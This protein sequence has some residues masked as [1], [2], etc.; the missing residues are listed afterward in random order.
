MDSSPAICTRR[1]RFTRLRTTAPPT[2]LDTTKPIRGGRAAR[3]SVRLACTTRSRDPARAPPGRLVTAVNSAPVRSRCRAGSTGCPSGGELGAALPATGGED[4]PTGAGA[5]PVA[6]AVRLGAT[7][8]VR[9]ERALAHGGW[10]SSGRGCLDGCVRGV[11]SGPMCGPTGAERADRPRSSGDTVGRELSFGPLAS[12]PGKHGASRVATV[13]AGE[14]G[15]DVSDAVALVC[16]GHLIVSSQ[17]G[18]R[19]AS[20]PG[21]VKRPRS[22][23]RGSPLP[24]TSALPGGDT[25]VGTGRMAEISLLRLRSLRW[26]D[27]L[28]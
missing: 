4:R 27:S 8:V 21:R 23:Q 19:Y 6:E 18:Q 1:R 20:A 5:H 25:P 16:A 10:L 28:P 22:L 15:R 9:L 7:T 17:T 12:A 26:P 3:E 24:C 11:W 2:F 14:N 13:S